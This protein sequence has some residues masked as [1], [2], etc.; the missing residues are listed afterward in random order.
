MI[1]HDTPDTLC[2]VTL[3]QSV[4]GDRWNL[5]ILREIFLGNLRFEQ[6]QAH[7]GATPQI[8]TVRLKRL[9]ANGMVERRL[10]SERPPRHEYRP[11]AKGEAFHAVLLTLR[12]WGEGWCKAPGAE[13]A[14]EYIHCDCEGLAGLG[15]ACAA[16]GAP[17]EWKDL[18][19]EPG[20]AYGKEREAR[21]RA[22]KARR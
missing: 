18:R 14:V 2:P 6:I 1:E 13:R 19:A 17:V 22:F 9:E 15:P 21:W 8:L 5:L 11:T 10:Y 20:V 12:A 7:T 3:S 16:C 4:A